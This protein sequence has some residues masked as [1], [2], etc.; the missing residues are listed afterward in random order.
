[1]A[2]FTRRNV[3]ALGDDWA[4]P[5]LWYARGVQALNKRKLADPLSWKFFAAIHGFDRS[6]WR[7]Q[8]YFKTGD[9]LPAST[10]QRRFWNQCQH[11]TWYFLPWHRG[12]LFAL[13]AAIRAE[14]VKLKGPED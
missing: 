10:L 2:T 11:V 4:D 9:K 3:Y 1:M 8:G 13:E 7:A 5:I 14:I 12:Y 6:L